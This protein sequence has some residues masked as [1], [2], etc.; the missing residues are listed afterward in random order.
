MENFRSKPPSLPSNQQTTASEDSPNGFKLVASIKYIRGL[1]EAILQKIK[2]FNRDLILSASPERSLNDFFSTLKDQ[3]PQDLRSQIIYKLPCSMCALIYIGLT[4]KQY[5]K[6][7]SKKHKRQQS[8]TLKG[9]HIT[10]KTAVTWT[11]TNI[12]STSAEHQLL[13]QV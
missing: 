12:C 9:G 11:S 1:S 10:S 13:H 6:E 4:W 3:T 7:R 5:L 2:S 8:R